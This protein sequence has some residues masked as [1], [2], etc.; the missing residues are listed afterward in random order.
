MINAWKL[1]GEEVRKPAWKQEY[2]FGG[3]PYNVTASAPFGTS[4]G[5]TDYSTSLR[6][7]TGV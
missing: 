4:P 6:P 2:S 7:R 5:P 3:K 1:L